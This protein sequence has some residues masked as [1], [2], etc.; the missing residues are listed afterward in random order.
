MVNFTQENPWI[1]EREA[2]ICCWEP[3]N[4]RG[5]YSNPYASKIPNIYLYSRDQM[6]SYMKMLKKFG[7]TGVQLIDC[8]YSW[9]QAGSVSAFHDRLLL[10]MHAARNNGL[11]ITLWVWAACFEGHGWK[12]HEA[13]YSPR[14][15]Y[16]AYSDPQV[17]ASFE[18][19]YD[20]YAELAPHID[21]LIGHFFDP[22]YLTEYQ[23]IFDYMKL[24]EHKCKTK[25]ENL[26]FAV[27]T[28][29]SPPDYPEKLIESGLNHYM[30][31]EL[32]IS[33]AMNGEQ[34]SDFRRAAVK[35]GFQIGIWGWYTIE[36]ESDQMASMYVNARVIKDRYQ[37]I[38]SQGD[39]SAPIVYWSEMEAC[40]LV[41]L[42]SLYC[43]A[44][45]LINPN[46]DPDRLLNEVA[47]MIWEGTD[48][49]D[50]LF[51]LLVIQDIRSGDNWDS[52]WW[53]KPDY[54]WGTQ[55]SEDDYRRLRQCKNI[56]ERLCLKKDSLSVDLP[57]PFKPWVLAGLIDPHIEQMMQLAAFKT[58]LG[59]LEEKH[60]EGASPDFIY[61][62][63]KKIIT[64][65][66]N[67]DTWV[68]TF[69]QIEQREQYK[70]IYEFSKKA[71]LPLPQNALR[72]NELRRC[73]LEK[74][75]VHQKG[76]LEPHLFD[77]RFIS[78]GY[79][80][81]PKE[82]ALSV[83]ESLLDDYLIEYVGEGLYQLA[84]WMDYRYQI[85]PV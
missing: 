47:H 81:Y 74:A 21:R 3:N 35:K 60:G 29:G 44:Q 76:K 82:E 39:Q 65:I 78:E 68:G 67:F 46:A 77:S 31:M 26:T 57:L 37:V 28:W 80:S 61:R 73:A 71:G 12:D 30:L 5:D 38:L 64:P 58:K 48:A 18:K 59:K 40:H 43:S 8:C 20:L 15:G 51:V 63:L 41:N 56:I 75:S 84:N 83:I 70:L 54:R 19:Y 25:N 69:L 11:K 14:Q 10:I 45:L 17:H 34:R 24:L 62:E 55:D 49:D 7:F 72:L 1:P 79:L 2:T 85:C 9:S 6:D 66:P 32:T 22:G 33:D 36:Y 4:V 16:T 52:Y 53:K 27:D 42:F 13:I 23:D 50:M